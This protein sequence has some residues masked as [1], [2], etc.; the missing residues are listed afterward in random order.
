MGP[1]TRTS[2]VTATAALLLTDPPATID[3]LVPYSRV[4]AEPH[5]WSNRA[6]TRPANQAS[7]TW[8]RRT[9]RLRQ[10]TAKAFTARRVEGLRGR[11]EEITAGLLDRMCRRTPP[12]DLLDEFAFSLPTAVICELLGS[13]SSSVTGSARGRRPSSDRS[14]TRRCAPVRPPRRVAFL[15]QD[16]H[17]GRGFDI[18]PTDISVG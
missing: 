16:D 8:I 17:Q 10:L 5:E 14:S 18:A 2:P 6:T 9:T 1:A 3:P 4:Y 15:V 11:V 12:V 7:S 13:R